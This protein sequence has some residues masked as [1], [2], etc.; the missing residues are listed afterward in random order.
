LN[1][2]SLEAKDY[3]NVEGINEFIEAFGTYVPEL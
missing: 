2:G 3:L 1:N